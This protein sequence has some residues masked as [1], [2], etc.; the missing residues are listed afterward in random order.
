[1]QKI[2]LTFLFVFISNFLFSQNKLFRCFV[3]ISTSDCINCLNGAKSLLNIPKEYNPTLVFKGQNKKQVSKILS[4]VMQLSWEKDKIMVSDSL[5]SLLLPE[6]TPFSMV[7]ILDKNNHILFQCE[8]KDLN[9]NNNLDKIKSF[10]NIKTY[11]IQK[12]LPDSIIPTNNYKL[13]HIA[14]NPHIFAYDYLA[15]TIHIFDKNTK[16]NLYSINKKSFDRKELYK[17]VFGDT[18]NYYNRIIAKQKKLEEVGKNRIEI[19][20]YVDDKEG[21][22]YLWVALFYGVDSVK[23]KQ[24][25][26]FAKT[27]IIK[28]NKNNTFEK[29]LN[30]EKITSQNPIIFTPKDFYG[31]GTQFSIFKEKENFYAMI[32]H[33]KPDSNISIMAEVNAKNNKIKLTNVKYLSIFQGTDYLFMDFK[34]AS[35]YVFFSHYPEFVNYENGER[36]KIKLDYKE[37]DFKEISIKNFPYM[38]SSVFQKGNEFYLLLLEK[39]DSCFYVKINQKGEIISKTLLQLPSEIT[40]TI[41]CPFSNFIFLSEKEIITL[42]NENDLIS[43][44]L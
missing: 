23:T 34:I 12:I 6:K 26:I 30:V 1:M 43:I 2:I 8:L 24:T 40:K 16:K 18:T 42:T 20:N 39:Q 7:H 38:L 3:T 5:Y 17:I 21:N 25:Y 19:S 37:Q 41:I 29:F 22:I 14:G 32:A 10:L 4:E 9:K 31:F 35:P 11:N 28:W 27:A 15:S 36:T 33:E 44:G 13:K